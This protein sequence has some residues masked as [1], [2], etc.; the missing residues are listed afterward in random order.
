MQ[1]CGSDC[2]NVY[3]TENDKNWV[4]E[5][6]IG[7][8]MIFKSQL[9][10]FDT[11][12]ITNKI[13]KKP[14][15]KCN[16]FV[17]DF[18]KEFVRIDYKI[19][20]DTFKLVEDYFIQIAAN[21]NLKDASPVIRLLNM[22]FS[23]SKNNLPELKESDLNSKWKNVYTFNK[24]NCPYINLNGKFGL[25]EFKWDKNYGLISYKNE[26]GEEWILIEEE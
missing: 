10:N 17:S 11:I 19:K 7:D 12:F 8:K 25:T 16:P 6:N 14:I 15:G 4:S 24:D 20:K 2:T 1:S 22:E 21:E 23:N 5:Y 3:F 13:I 18:D 26:N 9:N